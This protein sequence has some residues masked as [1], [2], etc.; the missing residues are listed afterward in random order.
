MVKKSYEK[1]EKVKTHLFHQ[2]IMFQGCLVYRFHL[3]NK[4]L[5]TLRRADSTINQY[6]QCR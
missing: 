5:V 1:V 3:E 6:N 4:N 2:C